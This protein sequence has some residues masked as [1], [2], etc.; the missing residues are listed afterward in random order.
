MV[1]PA[2]GTPTAEGSSAAS[3][4]ASQDA[5]YANAASMGVKVTK[6][7]AFGT[8]FNGVSVSVRSR[9]RARCGRYRA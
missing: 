8:L 3:V 4:K 2:L 9:R 1:C 6:R 7:Q 5:F